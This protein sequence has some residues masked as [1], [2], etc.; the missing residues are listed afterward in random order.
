M[1]VEESST[2]GFCASYSSTSTPKVLGAWDAIE[3][4]EVNSVKE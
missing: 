2:Q 4:P 1:S 3:G